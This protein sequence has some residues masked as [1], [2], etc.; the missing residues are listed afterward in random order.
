MKGKMYILT[1]FALNFIYNI[2]GK[3]FEKKKK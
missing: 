1:A 3:D 2:K